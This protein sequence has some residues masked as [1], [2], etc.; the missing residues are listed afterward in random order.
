MNL[1]FFHKLF[2]GITAAFLIFFIG[3]YIGYNNGETVI[4]IDTIEHPAESTETGLININTAT[5]EDLDLL[6]GI[7][8]SLAAAIIEY[9][10]NNGDFASTED[11]MNVKGI[12]LN[13]YR[14]IKTLITV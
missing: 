7:G 5:A 9:R 8:P 14:S 1:K 6:P 13:V 11:I 3:F 2:L 12:S 10:E 4:N